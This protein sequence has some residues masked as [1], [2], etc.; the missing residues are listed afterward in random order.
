MRARPFLLIVLA[1]C[2]TTTA[3]CALTIPGL[4]AHT[5]ARK[6]LAEAAEAPRLQTPPQ[7]EEHCP[8]YTLPTLRPTLADLETG[9]LRRG[10][11]IVHCDGMRALAVQTHAE[12]HRL[13]DEQQALRAKRARPWLLRRLP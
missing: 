1:A 3:G 4:A 8:L 5:A 9:Y 10:Y 2:S 11:Q 13:E 12:E 6:I 7:A